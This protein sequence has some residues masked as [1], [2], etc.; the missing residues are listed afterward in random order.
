MNEQKHMLCA[1]EININFCVFVVVSLY[2]TS[3]FR[4]YL[5]TYLPFFL[6]LISY[7]AYF[8]LQEFEVLDD[9]H[10]VCIT[11]F[12]IVIFSVLITILVYR[13][14]LVCLTVDLL[15]IEESSQVDQ[16][17]MVLNK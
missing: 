16:L 1:I 13:W 10:V 7:S 11:F 15:R 9:I 8:M 17:K 2:F 6:A 3:S 14:L 12:Y 5:C 4:W